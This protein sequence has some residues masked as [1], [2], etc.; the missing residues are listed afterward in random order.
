VPLLEERMR[1]PVD[2]EDDKDIEFI[3]FLMWKK[4]MREK[5]RKEKKLYSPSQ[6]A[7]CL[8]QVYMSR[9]Y[10]GPRMKQTRVEPNFYFMT[11]DWLH[12]KWQFVLH[13]MSREQVEGFTLVGCEFPVI[14][15]HGD[16]GGTIDAVAEINGEWLA[17]DFKGLN[18]RDF[19]R[20]VA[21]DVNLQYR[22]QITDYLML[23]NSNRKTT[24]PKLSRGLIVVENKGGPDPNHPI[25]LTEIS[26]GPDEHK[27][28]VHMRLEELRRHEE[29]NTIPLPEC[30]ST[31]SIQFN[32]CPFR[33]FCRKEVQEI[34]AAIRDAKSSDPT[35][36]R[37]AVPDP[38][39]R[40][41]S[42]GNS[43][44]GRSGTA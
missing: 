33:K 27:P 8:R 35:K 31:T 42:R 5:E 21:G 15:K 24:L 34:Q 38:E 22:I 13:K 17:I 28:E 9:N 10:T 26:I 1:Q 32:S 12:V 19:N 4:A 3:R 18:V 7:S 25:A 43:R 20:A 36:F 29:E 39:R 23:W 11:G 40:N 16:H 6:L 2:V 44:G 41:N 37:V 30:F 14:S